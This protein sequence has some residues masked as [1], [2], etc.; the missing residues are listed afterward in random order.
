ML[1][2]GYRAFCFRIVLFA[3]VTAIDYQRLAVCVPQSLQRIHCLKE[4]YRRDSAILGI[5]YLPAALAGNFLGRKIAPMPPPRGF[6]VDKKFGV[7]H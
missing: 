6:T 2:V 4:P 5:P 3:S 7:V 1:T